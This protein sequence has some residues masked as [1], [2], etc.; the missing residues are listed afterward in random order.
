MAALV[1]LGVYLGVS[2]SALLAL[3]GGL[4][5]LSASPILGALLGIAG[6]ASL[7]YAVAG[8]FGAPGFKN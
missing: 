2:L 3:F 5:E 4:L 7:L 8:L 1:R 6:M